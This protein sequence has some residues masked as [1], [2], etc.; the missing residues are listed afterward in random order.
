MHHVSRELLF[1]FPWEGVLHEVL[2]GGCHLYV[3]EVCCV[4]PSLPSGGVLQTLLEG[5]WYPLAHF[6]IASVD[7]VGAN[8]TYFFAFDK[9]VREEGILFSKP[10]WKLSF[11]KISQRRYVALRPEV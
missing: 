10:V 11:E 4:E 6:L 3:L 5:S 2:A 8:G 9:V 1:V 7:V